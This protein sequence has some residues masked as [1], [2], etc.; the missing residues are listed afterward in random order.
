[1]TA[2]GFDAETADLRFGTWQTE[3]CRPRSRGYARLTLD[4]G[5][6]G[7]FVSRKR[8]NDGDP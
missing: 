7:G 2:L 1:M 3:I 5:T 6:R 8:L 4:Q